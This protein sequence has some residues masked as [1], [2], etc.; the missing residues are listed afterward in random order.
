MAMRDASYFAVIA[1][2]LT[3]AGVTALALAA[4]TAPANAYRWLAPLRPEENEPPAVRRPSPIAAATTPNPAA[5]TLTIAAQGGAVPAGNGSL[6][7]MQSGASVATNLVQSAYDATASLLSLGRAGAYSIFGAVG[8]VAWEA[9]YAMG[10][11]RTEA[12]NPPVADPVTVR[13]AVD[14]PLQAPPEPEALPPASVPP[15]LA[16]GMS[17]QQDAGAL[18]HLVYDHAA[19]QPDGRM[20][21][22]KPLQR[23]FSVRTQ[24]VTAAD[25]PVLLTLAGRI[26]ADPRA[27]GHVEASL[28]GRIA[29]PSK[30][31]PVL[32]EK[33]AKDQVLAFISPVVALSDRT[34]TLRD[35]AHLTS[36]IRIESESLERLK[37][38][39][40]V[41][42]RDGKIYQSQARIDGLRRERATLLPMLDTR[43]VLRAPTAGVISRTTASE[44][45]MVH[46]SE[47]IFDIVDP[48][49]LWIEAMAPDPTAAM[50]ADSIVAA[51]ARTPEGQMLRIS[52]VGSGLALRQQATPILFRIHNPPAGLR[53]DR[54][55]TVALQGRRTQR[56]VT[57]PREAV[58]T[59]VDGV[60]EIWEQIAP[61]LFAS[62]PVR[63]HELDG[64]SVLV[65]DGLPDGASIVI[66]GTRL[67]AQL[68]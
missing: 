7:I 49:R 52:Y 51:S 21:V 44:G 38:F 59:S 53:L 22:P 62:H 24:R 68:Q 45:A 64:D 10:I 17:M 46:P 6:P 34:Q 65:T 54:P 33:V 41:P 25:I 30:G 67:M 48:E 47:I 32:G 11:N 61:E 36:E 9:S 43:E 4:S 8:Q 15:A 42:F 56:G 27:H 40:L 23:L 35:I 60:P 50:D 13:D 1:R 19:R 2:R 57:V 63:M 37:Q 12:V 16:V 3:C 29:A 58:A 26:V 28:V 14:P 55:V 39:A 20:F 5:G 66:N 18:A 31:L